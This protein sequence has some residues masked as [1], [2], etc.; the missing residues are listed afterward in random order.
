M[1][2]Q[3]SPRGEAAPSER[4]PLRR[5]GTGGHQGGTKANNDNG[6]KHFDAFLAYEG[7]AYTIEK[8]LAD[9]VCNLETLQR[10]GTYLSELAVKQVKKGDLRQLQVYN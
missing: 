5:S 4:L 7:R 6:S 10:F 8:S 3:P 2:K 1:V 9:D